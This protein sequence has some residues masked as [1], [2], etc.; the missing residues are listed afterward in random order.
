MPKSKRNWS[1]CRECGN[2][3][4][5]PQSS[6]ICI[7]CGKKER[8][9][10]IEREERHARERDCEHGYFRESCPHCELEEAYEENAKL[11]GQTSEL[12]QA[13]LQAKSVAIKEFTESLLNSGRFSE[14]DEQYI[15]L[16]SLDFLEVSKV[17]QGES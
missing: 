16:K 11:R 2:N 13:L 1:P 10:R 6:D 5:N 9:A 14:K 15:A 8:A 7:S 4:K 3:H 17:R 12:E